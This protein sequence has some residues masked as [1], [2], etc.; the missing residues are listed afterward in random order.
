MQLTA[1]PPYP[2]KKTLITVN[3]AFKEPLTFLLGIS[4][5]FNSKT[6]Q[7]RW[8]DVSLLCSHFSFLFPPLQVLRSGEKARQTEPVGQ[9][10]SEAAI[11][12]QFRSPLG[13][14]DPEE[15]AQHRSDS[16]RFQEGRV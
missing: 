9:C 7:M 10:R 4:T 13:R 11:S 5:A 15:N 6:A 8:Q 2:V 16:G 3:R 12:D 14:H 1:F